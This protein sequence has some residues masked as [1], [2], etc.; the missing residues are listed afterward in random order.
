MQ[1]IKHLP[2]LAPLSQGC[3]GIKHLPFL[4]L[5]AATGLDGSSLDDWEGPP[6]WIAGVRRAV[7]DP[8]ILNW[9]V[10][11]NLL[12]VLLSGGI[13]ALESPLTYCNGAFLKCQLR[14]RRAEGGTC[15]VLYGGYEADEVARVTR[16]NSS[17]LEHKRVA[18]ATGRWSLLGEDG[19][20]SAPRELE[21]KICPAA[22]A[23]WIWDNLFFI[24]E[25][26][27][28]AAEALSP[29]LHQGSMSL[30]V[31]LGAK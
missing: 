16:S 22:C 13:V 14:H 26:V 3:T 27:A 20:W 7:A 15:L 9:V 17:T 24:P 21:E 28:A 5:Q 19:G 8:C 29:I 4:Q 18:V 11:T 10:P 12:A 30:R 25:G 23:A 6:A 2:D 1:C 31:E